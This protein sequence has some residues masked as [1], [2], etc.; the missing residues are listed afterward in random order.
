MRGARAR[1]SLES[2][3]SS[4]ISPEFRPLACLG[5]AF[6][7]PSA[8]APRKLDHPPGSVPANV[9]AWFAASDADALLLDR[10]VRQYLAPHSPQTWPEVT[11]LTLLFGAATLRKTYGATPLSLAELAAAAGACAAAQRVARVF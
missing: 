3:P 2:G 7:A 1:L 5:R 10:G 8:M 6:G 4:L 11:R 9:T